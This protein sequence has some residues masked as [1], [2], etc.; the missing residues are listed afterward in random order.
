MTAPTSA[1]KYTVVFRCAL[2]AGVFSFLFGALLLVDYTARVAQDPLNAPEYVSLKAR[3]KASPAD[4]AVKDDLRQLDLQLRNEYFQR[5]QF[6]TW[7]AWL[8]L[9]SVVLTLACAK[10]AAMLHRQLPQPQPRD[11]PRDPEE[12]LH[13][14]SRW[15]VAGLSGVLVLGTVGLWAGMRGSVDLAA[16][17]VAEASGGVDSVAPAAGPNAAAPPVALAPETQPP[18]PSP[19]PATPAPPQSVEP[20]TKPEAQAEPQPGPQ[21]EPTPEPKPE[22]AAQP[23]PPKQPA[24]EPAAPTPPAPQAAGPEPG[25]DTAAGPPT[26]EEW[27]RNWPRFRGPA[28]TGVSTFADAPTKWDGASGEG[29]RWKTAIPLPGN[30]S[31]IVWGQRVFVTGADEARRVVYCCDADSGNLLWEAEAPGTPD[32]TAA[33]PKVGEATG[34]AAPTPATDGRRVYAMFANGDIAAVDFA[35]QV[36]WSRSL[37]MPKNTYGHATSL[38]MAGGLVLVQFDQGTK[39]D[40][41]SKLLALKAETGETAW[42]A[43]REVPNSWP[44][45]LVIEHAGQPQ[46]ITAAD[47]WVIAYAPADGKEIWRAKCLQADVGPSPTY[48][49]GVVFVANEFPGMA[50]IRPDGTGDVTDSH[51]L[52][53]ADVGSPDCC[54]PL[55]TDQFL[56]VLASFG[57]LTCYDA[58][59]GGEP[60]WEH[61]FD[62]GNFSSSPTLVSNLVY[63]FDEDGKAYIVEPT[64]EECKPVAEAELGEP[65][66]TSPAFQD[67]RIYV[68]GAEHLYCIGNAAP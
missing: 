46:I 58:K 27:R 9:G 61:D 47:P 11:V 52:W 7:G 56:L 5:R 17:Q 13:A 3:L 12:Q 37:G 22:P 28:G 16:V 44:T 57:T 26:D 59:E 6:S 19:A 4:A 15:A 62:G 2:V 51:V 31:P 63:L 24:M 33:P 30:S 14:V 39:Q 60:L 54:S 36:R 41:A 68:R 53:E 45:P 29:I 10:Q 21:P 48:A 49:G 8:L 18:A 38:A 35:G 34:F 43:P 64:A 32:S 66:V 40:K 65:C 23:E 25:P 67:G 20:A 1:Q 50:A 42:E 55:A